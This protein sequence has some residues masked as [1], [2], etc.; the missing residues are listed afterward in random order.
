MR[1]P[2]QEEETGSAK[3]LRWMCDYGAPGTAR[4]PG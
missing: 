2:L 4:R 1:S 3:A